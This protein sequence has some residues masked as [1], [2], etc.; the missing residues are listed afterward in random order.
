VKLWITTLVG[1][2]WRPY[3]GWLQ[4]SRRQ[5]PIIRIVGGVCRLPLLAGLLAL[6]T[7]AP[8]V[9]AED[10][11]VWQFAPAQAPPAPA[12]T[13]PAPYAVP[14]GQVGQIS[15]WAP[16]RG[17]LITGGSGPVPAGLYAYDGASW[18][19]LASVCGG[20]SGRIAWAGPDEFWTIADQRAGQ[21]VSGQQSAGALSSISLCHFLDGQ[22]VG[23]YAMPLG[24]PDSYLPMN[25]AACLA[26]NDCWFGGG[27]GPGPNGGAAFHLH[28]DGSSV[29]VVYE[30]EDH[31]VDDIVNFAG[32]L[33][34]SVRIQGSDTYLPEESPSHPAVL[35]TIL[36]GETP[37]G[38]SFAD[39]SIFTTK[40]L[41]DY[42]V[43]VV[44]AALQ[45]FSLSTD[46]T[47]LGEG[48]SQ[49]W[50]GAD[51]AEPS[52]VPAGSNGAHL[53]ILHYASG[54]WAE[55]EPKLPPEALLGGAHTQV[56]GGAEEEG[57]SS[58]LAAEPGTESAWLSLKGEGNSARVALL[59]A[60][61]AITETDDL[62]P[63]NLVGYRGNAGPIVCPAL[64][65]C[66]MATNAG[67]GA[68]AGWLF[69]LTDGSEYPQDTDPSF[70][71]VIDYRPPDSGIPVIYPDVPPVD[72]SLANQQLLPAPSA[73][74]SP[75]ASS[76]AAVKHTRALVT[77]VKS[78]FLH[79]RVLVIS[80]T[81]SA[82]AHVQLIARRAKRVVAKTRDES[83]HPGNHRLSLALNPKSWPT[84]LQFKATPIGASAPSSGPSLNNTVSTG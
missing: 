57:I 7:F 64:H 82:R 34:E 75:T 49:L 62:G 67:A 8:A 45:G 43:G 1:G 17:L 29:S 20:A 69:H 44:A 55:I 47:P 15:F 52:Q 13:A 58:A 59:Q 51:P 48:A 60:N 10:G 65:D 22:V 71:G 84:A 25:A 27:D 77:H 11:A 68:S 76:P 79:R 4:M 37:D 39:L 12:G 18:H 61:G 53:T 38:D 54:A 31:V 50:A 32:K 16:N 35:H 74:S 33:Y 24:Q 83:L 66:W 6:L 73:P 21:E 81:L 63:Q 2:D 28:W 19:Q 14:V 46:G 42:G 72:D 9:R 36:S 41:P 78:R 30:P 23:S 5:L 26:P 3:R 70:A 56:G 40:R 80:F